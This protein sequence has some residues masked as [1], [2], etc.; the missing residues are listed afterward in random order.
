MDRE[1]FSLVNNTTDNVP[2]FGLVRFTGVDPATAAVI[3]GK[4]DT[5]SD[6]SVIVVGE[7]SIASGVGMGKGTWHREVVIAF[8]TADGAPVTGDSWG[9]KAGS[10]LAR[11][12]KSGF[13]II[14]NIRGNVV[15]ALRMSTLSVADL[16]AAGCA[17][18]DDL[19]P[20]DCLA[21]FVQSGSGRCSGVT[22]VQQVCLLYDCKILGWIAASPIT[23]DT[24]DDWVLKILPPK[25]NGDGTRIPLRAT[26]TRTVVSG[27]PITVCGSPQPCR[28]I[29]GKKYA[30]FTFGGTSLCSGVRIPCGK[31]SFEVLIG[32]VSCTDTTDV[33]NPCMVTVPCCP[34]PIPRRLIVATSN[35]RPAGV[36]SW[37]GCDDVNQTTMVTYDAVFGGWLGLRSTPSFGSSYQW[38]A[39]A[40]N[41]GTGKW[42]VRLHPSATGADRPASFAA[43]CAGS[44]EVDPTACDPFAIAATIDVPRECIVG[45]T[46][47]GDVSWKLD[48]VVSAPGPDA[49]PCPPGTDSTAKWYCVQISSSEV[50]NQ[51][52]GPPAT[53]N[54]NPG[55]VLCLQISDPDTFTGFEVVEG[56]VTC[57]YTAVIISSPYDTSTECGAGCIG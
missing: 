8:D 16:L 19:D 11:K 14:G 42:A 18:Y 32:C 4:P 54:L 29:D 10:F 21:A 28:I 9:S 36:G 51:P 26:L 53:C 39:I 48:A 40:C 30:V 50:I 45:C 17:E 35:P 22:G 37:I 20:R 43:M 49:D 23:T 24:G 56:D 33:D 27:S 6:E 2:A 15:D 57:G 38:I 12:G 47:P 3:I 7:T 34:N 5:D 44:A 25:C 1:W 46:D 13:K 55:D 52:A 41:S 31:N